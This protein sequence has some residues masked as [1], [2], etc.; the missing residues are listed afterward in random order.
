[1]SARKGKK[2]AVRRTEAMTFSLQKRITAKIGEFME[3]GFGKS[4]I[5]NLALGEFFA[6][7]DPDFDRWFQGWKVYST[8]E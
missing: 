5:G 2:K 6:K 4:D 1:M 8:E 3:R 7:D